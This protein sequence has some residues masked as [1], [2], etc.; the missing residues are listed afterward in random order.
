MGLTKTS[1]GAK[2][3]AKSHT[4]SNSKINFAK[5]CDYTITLAGNPNTGKST[6]F[7]SL[8]GM[9]QHTG[10]WTG[11]TVESAA[12][13]TT[14]KNKKFLLVDIPGTYSLIANS[15][16]EIVARDYIKSGNSDVTVVVVDATRLERNLNL[17]Y[18]IMNLTDNVIVCVN[19]LDEASKKGIN[20]DLELLSQELGIPVVGTIARKKGTLANL[21]KTIFLVCSGKII[22]NPIKVKK[23]K[24]LSN[25]DYINLIFD[26]A[27]S[28][29]EKVVKINNEKNYIHNN[30][31]LDK[32]LTSK[33]FGIPI[34][35]LFFCLIFWITI[36]GAN[37]PSEL[38][39]KLFNFIGPYF[40]GF[41][42][43]LHS[44]TWLTSLLFDG[45][46]K[47]V[48]WIV[49]VMLPPMAIFFP[50]FTLLEDL[51]Y[52]PRIAFNL[53]KCFQKCGSSGKQALT[54][55]MGFGCNAAGVVGCRIISSPRERLI[56]IITNSFVPC[57]GRFPLLITISTIFFAGSIYSKISLT[58]GLISTL[59]VSLVILIGICFEMII[60]KII[61]SKTKE[62]VP[63]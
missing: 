1:T 9:H 32:I 45:V 39:S 15:E 54:M 23:K 31:K 52:L 50:L 27:H 19:L 14:F 34:M 25:E 10:N 43:W 63:K 42:I 5:G 48:T 22:C 36:V 40:E 11:K 7:N 33:K 17:V 20:I 12:G 35:I 55:C 44:P 6:I 51:G 26:K 38:L 61:K 37:Y 21:L 49:S 56:A 18:Q 29:Y 2:I 60:Q 46:Y 13:I 24:G 47:T 57:N 8:T 16:E 4:K 58:T 62:G 59:I 28:V 3:N 53:D 41:L 30:N